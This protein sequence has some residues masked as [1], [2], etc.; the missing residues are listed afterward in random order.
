MGASSM[1]VLRPEKKYE[2]LSYLPP[3]SDE[4]I[5]KQVVYLVNNGWSPCVEFAA[6]SEADTNQLFFA[7]P[8]LYENRYWTM[9]KLPLFGCSDPQ[10][11]LTRSRLARRSTLDAESELSD[12]TESD[13]SRWLASSSE[14]KCS[15]EEIRKHGTVQI[16]RRHS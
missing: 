12:S 15:L 11:V 1:Q 9:W 3:L 10:Q 16:K 8:A 4:D 6:Q 7:G 14:S 2:C 5:A 13:R